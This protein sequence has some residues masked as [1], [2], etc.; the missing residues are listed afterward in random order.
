[1]PSACPTPSCS[2]SSSASSTWSRWS[3]PPSPAHWSPWSRW[4]ASPLTAAIIN[5]VFTIV[6]R[7]AEDYLINPRVLKRTVD[8]RPL[9]TIVAVLLGGALL[10]I[11]GALIAVP[12]AAAIQLII[13][14]V[15]YPRMDSA[16]TQPTPRAAPRATPRPVTD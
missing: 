6:Y 8:V 14:E 12:T 10:G 16:G 13:T 1:M 5:I 2:R 9:V 3:A 4:P 7:L 11:I 15:I